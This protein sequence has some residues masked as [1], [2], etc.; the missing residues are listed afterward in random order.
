LDSIDEGYNIGWFL[1]IKMIA[2]TEVVS[3]MVRVEMV[4]MVGFIGGVSG[5][6]GMTKP[7]VYP[8]LFTVFLHNVCI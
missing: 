2:Y 1:S 6:Y 3:G 7:H 4:E 5:Q 8:S